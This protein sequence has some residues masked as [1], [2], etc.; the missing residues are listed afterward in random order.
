MNENNKRVGPPTHEHARLL[1]RLHE[2]IAEGNGD[3]DEADIVRDQM[4][5]SWYSMNYL[6]QDRV[7]S[8][9]GDLYELSE[10]GP[11]PLA[12]T[13]EERKA[14]GQEWKTAYEAGDWDKVLDLLRRPPLD[15][16]RQDIFLLRG[17]AWEKLGDAEVAAVFMK[18]AERLGAASMVGA[19]LA[20]AGA[21]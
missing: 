3:S 5:P 15:V 4:E 17:R 18:E 6:E 12:M 11:K 19:D 8:L 13:A 9:S 21:A 1:I 10:N 2:L 20:A 14:W 7:G 16:S